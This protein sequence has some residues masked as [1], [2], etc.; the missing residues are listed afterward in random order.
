MAVCPVGLCLATFPDGSCYNDESACE[1]Q[2][3][4]A[5][6]FTSFYRFLGF[7]I[8]F[9]RPRDENAAEHVI[10]FSETN[11]ALFRTS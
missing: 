4:Q 7:R 8:S 3:P 11:L 10:N 5:L 1:L 6:N 9:P 2:L